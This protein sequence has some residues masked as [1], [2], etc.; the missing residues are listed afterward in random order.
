MDHSYKYV[1]KD[2][3]TFLSKIKPGSASVRKPPSGVR[4]WVAVGA[5]TRVVVACPAY[6]WQIFPVVLLPSA[7]P[8]APEGDRR[9]GLLPNGCQSVLFLYKNK[10]Q[11]PSLCVRPLQGLGGGWL[12]DLKPVWLWLFQ[13][14]YCRFTWLYC[15]RLPT[16]WPL[17]GIG[18]RAFCRMAVNQFCFFIRIKTRVRHC[19]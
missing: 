18:A 11:G 4:G 5:E 15:Y 16:P 12:L 7:H 1:N 13:D 3:D 9:T 14:R 8:L 2:K 17:K 19:A 6:V 10:N